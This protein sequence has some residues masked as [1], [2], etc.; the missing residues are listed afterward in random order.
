MKLAAMIGFGAC[1]ALTGTASGQE[2][3]SLAP[4]RSSRPAGYETGGSFG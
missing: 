2:V 1:L 3:F 4:H